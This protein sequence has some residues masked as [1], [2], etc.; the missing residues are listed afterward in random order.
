MNRVEAE[1]GAR[2]RALGQVFTPAPIAEWMAR[3]VRVDRSRRILDPA[4]GTGVFVDA[5]EGVLSACGT[6]RRPI[7]DLC[8][9]DERM[10]H[11]AGGQR[12]GA[13]V[14]L[15]RLDFVSGNFPNPYDAIVANPPYVRHHD[16]EYPERI[17][18]EFDRMCGRRLRRQTNLYGLF[19]VKIWALL[20][21]RGRAAVIVPAEFLN[22]DF[23]VPLK[24]H[25]LEENAMDAIVHFDPSARVFANA[26]TTSAI[27][28]LRRGRA[29]KE[30]VRLCGVASIAELRR[31]EMK[32][33]EGWSGDDLVP[34]EKWS[35]YFRKTRPPREQTARLGDVAVCM[36]GIATGANDYFTLR[37]SDRRRW[38][39]D[40]RDVTPCITKAQQLSAGAAT[41]RDVR[42]IIESDERIFLFSPRQPLAAGPRNYLGEGRRRGI[43]NRYLPAHRPIWY[44]PEKRSPAPILVSVFAR[45]AFRFVLNRAGVLNLTAYHGIFP[46]A[47]DPGSVRL[48]FE[49]LISRRGQAAL[50]RHCRVYADGLLKVEPRDVEAMPIPRNLATALQL[51]GPAV[52]PTSRRT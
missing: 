19:L 4:V 36:R 38:Q 51:A 3:W 15:R 52:Q 8:D 22:A 37:E 46:H 23:G 16:F 44:L 1:D 34:A 27:V 26:L 20:S 2:R 12:R 9:V 28:L 35:P 40:R 29:S 18:R 30:P 10:I 49:Y 39:I 17:W 33:D 14:R 32:D 13:E 50:R 21:A 7:I 31:L 25:F 43:P 48:L 5:I 6:R 24:A 45:G 42:R 11:L 47:D 41:A